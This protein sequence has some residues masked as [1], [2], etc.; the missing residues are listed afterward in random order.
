MALCAP[1]GTDPARTMGDAVS[2]LVAGYS[3]HSRSGLLLCTHREP[4]DAHVLHDI[5][6]NSIL[7]RILGIG[8]RVRHSPSQFL[9]RPN[10]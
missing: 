6:A 8:E 4:G 2:G 9:D 3:A 7:V 5:P 1:S 10:S